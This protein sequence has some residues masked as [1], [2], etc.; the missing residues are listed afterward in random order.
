M[1]LAALEVQVALDLQSFAVGAVDG[2]A[3]PADDELSGIARHLGTLS[4]AFL[5]HPAYL[6][7]LGRD[8]IHFTSARGHA[9]SAAGDIAVGKGM[10]LSVEVIAPGIDTLAAVARIL[11]SERSAGHGEVIVRFHTGRA[12]V[13]GVFFIVSHSAGDADHVRTAF[14]QHIVVGTDAFLHCAG[15][16]DD[17]R[18]V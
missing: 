8:V 11:D 18:A 1:G 7:A 10:V 12:G 15:Y 5:G 6:D 16:G 3:A 13:F 2:D 17:Q 4:A 9:E 14:D